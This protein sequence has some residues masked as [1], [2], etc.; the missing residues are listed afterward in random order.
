MLLN[1]FLLL[2]YDKHKA[3]KTINSEQNKCK[4]CH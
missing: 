4:I 2:F 1:V 3:H